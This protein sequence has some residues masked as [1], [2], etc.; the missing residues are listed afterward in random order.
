MLDGFGLLCSDGSRTSVAGSTPKIGSEEAWEFVCP[1]WEV[2]RD[3][4]ETCPD[5]GKRGECKHNP[6]YMTQAC[7]LTCNS[8]AEV[9]QAE[10]ALGLVAMDVR[11]GNYVDAVRFHCGTGTPPPRPEVIESSSVEEEGGGGGS[12]VEEVGEGEEKAVHR[13][14]LAEGDETLVVVDGVVLSD[15]TEES[16]QEEMKRAAGAATST[17]DDAATNTMAAAPPSL[18]LGYPPLSEVY[19]ASDWFGGDG[20]DEC[21]LACH[22]ENHTGGWRSG[23][24]IQSVIVAAGSRVDRLE[25]TKCSSDI[26]I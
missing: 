16:D 17:A 18:P 8:C 25:L 15:E 13:T 10:G 24:H 9:K 6:Q 21:G 3:L 4:N 19:V 14:P 20:G 7:P 1:G 2:C 23:G 26:G 12:T 11:A 5:W 22:S